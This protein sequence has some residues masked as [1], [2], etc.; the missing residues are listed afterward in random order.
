MIQH[1]LCNNEVNFLNNNPHFCSKSLNCLDYVDKI[2]V[3]LYAD[4]V[5]YN[6]FWGILI[7]VTD[8]IP[9]RTTKSLV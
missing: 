7:S 5:S 3:H 6:E 9:Q 4:K 1:K 2:F 8:C